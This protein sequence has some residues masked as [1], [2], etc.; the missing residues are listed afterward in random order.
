MQKYYKPYVYVH[1]VFDKDAKTIYLDRIIF[2]S[3]DAGTT[4][5]RTKLDAILTPYTKLTQNGS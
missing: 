1:F 2:L 3:I 4:Y 5:K